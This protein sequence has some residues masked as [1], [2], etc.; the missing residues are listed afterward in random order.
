[1]TDPAARNRLKLDIF[2][3]RGKYIYSAEIAVEEGSE[4]GSSSWK[5]DK[6]YLAV[7]TE[8]GDIKLVKYQIRL[9]GGAFEKLPPGPPQNFL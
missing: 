5:K 7:E 3:P 9:P 4:I 1:L 8:E 2:S 6:L